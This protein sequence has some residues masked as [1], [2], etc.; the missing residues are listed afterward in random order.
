MSMNCEISPAVIPGSLV[1]LFL[2]GIEV[3]IEKADLKKHAKKTEITSSASLY[4]GVLWEEYAPGPSGGSLSWE[5]KLRVG[6]VVNPTSIRQG[7]IYPIA[8]YERRPFTNGPSDPGSA[9]TFNLY[10]DDSSL[11]FDP[12]TGVIDWKVSGTVTGPIVDAT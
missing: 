8:L 1:G 9:F 5:A 10:I 12:K 7:G 3:P 6:Q 11:T 2:C 4:G